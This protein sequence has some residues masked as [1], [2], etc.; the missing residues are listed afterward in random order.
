MR[1]QS[2]A[3]LMLRNLGRTSWVSKNIGMFFGNNTKIQGCVRENGEW[4]RERERERERD[5][6][7]LRDRLELLFSAFERK[8]KM[9]VKF[10]F[11]IIIL[12]SNAIVKSFSFLVFFFFLALSYF[13]LSLFLEFIYEKNIGMRTEKLESSQL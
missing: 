11:L 8:W 5:W 13:S 3:C 4:M 6:E 2:E 1:K 7:R 10:N 9:W 12:Q